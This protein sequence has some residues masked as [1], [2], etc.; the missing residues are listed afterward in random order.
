MEGVFIETP[1]Q[2]VQLKINNG[3]KKIIYIYMY[4]IPSLEFK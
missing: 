1:N 2:L 3:E 4:Y